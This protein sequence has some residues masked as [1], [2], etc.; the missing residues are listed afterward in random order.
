MAPSTAT[1]I[2]A[3]FSTLGDGRSPANYRPRSIIY[4][5][6]DPADAVYYIESGKVQLMVVSAHG[7]EGVIAM[8]SAGDFF[9]EGCLAGQPVYMA[10]A[11]AMAKSAIRR[12][13]KRAMINA[14]HR[15]SAM[16]E[17]FL[18]FLLSRN[19]QIEADLIDQLFNSSER[20]LARLLLLLANFGKE[21]KME[22]VIPRINQDILAAK[23][24][25]TR[26]RINFFMNKFR[27][28]GFIEYNGGLKV[29]TSL[30]NIIVH[31]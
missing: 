22:A 12:I 27:K 14:L 10:S 31:D 30:L 25:T 15:N 9:G 20:R 8:L 23:V 5:Q 13:D 1:D 3:F 29:H 21:G 4:R 24:G 17:M 16:S 18:G 28:L 2:E 26:S 11:S 6:G 7:K 19:I